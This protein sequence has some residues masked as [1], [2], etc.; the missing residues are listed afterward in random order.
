MHPLKKQYNS[1][2]RP[3]LQ[4]KI[5][6]KNILSIPRVEKVVINARLSSKR[7]PKFI[8]TL[9]QTLNR[10]SGQRPVTT[11]ARKSIAGFK[12]REGLVVGSMVTLRGNRMWDFLQK[13]VHITFARIRDFRGIPES[14][15]DSTGN[16][17]YGFREHTAFPEIDADEIENIHGLQVTIK[18]SA[19]THEEGLELF[20]MMGFPFKKNEK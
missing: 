6:R 5:G 15:V 1:E 10:I 7:D 20:K 16:F 17:N 9:L 8:E 18:T 12:I 2:I 11:K 14:A 4:E 19:R 13:L 3:A